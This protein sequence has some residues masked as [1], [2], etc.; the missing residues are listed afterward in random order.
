MFASHYGLDNLFAIV[1]YNHFGDHED[2][3]KMMNLQPLDS[4]F[5]SFG[6]ETRVESSGNNP[7]NVARA[8]EE[9][10]IIKGRP[11]CLIADTVKNCG[12]PTWEKAHFHQVTGAELNAG[13]EEGRRLLR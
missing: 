11:H 3:D 1:D 10:G 9:L 4:R 12:V 6:W 2:V 7:N 8:L 5:R 13:L